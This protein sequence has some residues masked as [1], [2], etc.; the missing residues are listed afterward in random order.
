MYLFESNNKAYTDLFVRHLKNFIEDLSLF[1]LTEPLFLTC[2]GGVDSIV[3]VHAINELRRFGYSNELFVLHI[4]HGTRKENKLEQVLV[5]NF[6]AKLH[7]KIKSFQLNNLKNISNFEKVARDL[8]Y[9][10]FKE[11]A[12]SHKILF[13]HHI[14]DSFEWS[15]MQ[16][17]KSS[18]LN[19]TLG[20]PVVNGQIIRPF[21]A[22]TKS[23]I[24]RYANYFKL[25]YVNDPTNEYEI[26]ER[27]YLRKKIIPSMRS[28][29]PSYLKHYVNQQNEFARK[30]NI[31]QSGN[32]SSFITRI[33]NNGIQLYSLE[34]PAKLNGIKEQIRDAV[35]FLSSD[36]RGQIQKQL[37]NV[38]QA[39]K[40]NKQGPLSF[41][42]GVKLVLNYNH[43]FLYTK[44]YDSKDSDYLRKELS[45]EHSYLPISLKEFKK[46]VLSL[47]TTD[48]QNALFPNWVII[49]KNNQWVIGQKRPHPL[50]PLVTD[51]WIKNNITFVS[52]LSL[53]KQWQKKA[54]SKK[55]LRLRFLSFE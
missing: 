6:A 7:I 27:N 12:K 52:A 8:R 9:K 20:I 40:N 45:L 48:N 1:N 50:W 15:M 11:N 53:L 41:S 28:K 14:D 25:D 36:D 26:Y 55:I 42:G 13:A 32:K 51:F 38:L 24:I 30:L 22:V 44:G 2:S 33:S 10:I 3:L 35:H 23:Q 39:I 5:E 43:L 49:E 17:L 16:R 18:N 54:N 47:L 37:K 31:H 19:S 21:M 29:Y 46:L 4:N 34:S